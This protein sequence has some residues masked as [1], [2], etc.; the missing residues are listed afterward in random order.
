ML[1]IRIGN[2]GISELQALSLLAEEVAR[3]SYRKGTDQAVWVDARDREE[4][5][6]IVTAANAHEGVRASIVEAP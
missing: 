3:R 4:A 1:T 2:H 5:D 6:G